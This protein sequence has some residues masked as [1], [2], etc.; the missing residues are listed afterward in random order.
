MVLTWLT[1]GLS[2]QTLTV[3][4]LEEFLTSSV[5]LK[6]TDKEVADYV[7][8][9]KLTS[10]L[11]PDFL[12]EMKALGVGPRTEQALKALSGRSTSLP[13]APDLKPKERAAPPS[14]PAPTPAEQKRLLDWM[15]EYASN[16][17]KNLP[18]FICVQVTRRY[19]DPTGMELWQKQDTV[20]TKLT[21][22]E[23]HENYDVVMVN[24]Q[25]VQNVSLKDVGGATS[26]GEFGTML[27]EIFSA[28]S[29]TTFRWLRYGTLRGRLMHVF[30]YDV[31]RDRSEWTVKYQDLESVVAAHEGLIYVDH[32][33]EL[34]M[35]IAMETKG[36]PSSY[37][38]SKAWTTL[39]YDFTPIGDQEFVLPLRAEVRM[40]AAKFLS[41]NEVEFRLYRKYGADTTIT[42][43]SDL[44][45]LDSGMIQEQPAPPPNQE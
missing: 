31:A 23:K 14:R 28:K 13:P 19:M 45:A 8:K 29:E 41:R 3:S 2:A 44:D 42:F 36:I 38:L 5:K 1:L 12:L 25:P 35:R 33:T 24:S 34:I 37:P 21:Y 17:D 15:R 4:K 40:R 10:Q 16:Y 20:T 30:F 9:I 26:T 22:F 7:S 18:D 6:A 32:D 11:P 39:D 43:D 27:R